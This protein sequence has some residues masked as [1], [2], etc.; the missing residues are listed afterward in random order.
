M[1]DLRSDAVQLT[2]GALELYY[3]SDPT[4]Q[5]CHVLFECNMG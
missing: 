3:N 5:L 1:F 2:K 4:E